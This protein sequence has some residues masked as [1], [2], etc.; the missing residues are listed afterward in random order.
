M[1]DLERRQFNEWVAALAIEYTVA[2]IEHAVRVI[3]E[4]A[5]AHPASV[6]HCDQLIAMLTDQARNVAAIPRT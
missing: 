2:G 5:A 6:A 1:D 3:G 4:Y